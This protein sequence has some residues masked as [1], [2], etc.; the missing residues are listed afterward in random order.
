MT[1]HS[2]DHP[3]F[4]PPRTGENS[5]VDFLGLRQANLDMMAEMIPSTNNVT[6]YVRPFSLVSWVFWKFYNLC[7][8]SGIKEPSREEIDHFREKIEVLFSWGARLH[9]TSGRVPGTG[10]APPKSSTDGHVQL[11][12]KDWKRVQSSTSLIAALWYGPASKIVTGLGFLMPVPG[13]TGFFRTTGVGI[14]LAKAL[15]VQLRQ[16][17]E[18]YDRLL[19]TLKPVMATENDAVAMWKLWSPEEITA[20]EREAFASALYSADEIG[21]FNSLAGKRSTTLALAM[22]Y[23]TQCTSA[24]TIHE[25]R[26]GMA[27]SISQGGKSYGLPEELIVA[28]N[29]WL[30]LQMRQLQRLSMECLLSWCE[31][32]IL[33]DRINETSAMAE[34]FIANWDGDEH[35]FDGEEAL[36]AM[37]AALDDQ[38]SDIDGFISAVLEER[39]ANP[40]DIIADIQRL[41]K[42][43]NLGYAQYA[44]TGI[45]LCVAYAG[46]A[47]DDARLLKLGG[48][49]R[50]SLDNLR[51]R[52]VGLG[53]VSVREAFQF[54]LESMIISQHFATAVN[55]FDGQNQRLRLTIEETGLEALVGKQWEPTVTEDRLATL[56]SLAAQSGLVKRDEDGFSAKT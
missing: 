32:R 40:F 7:E 19:E 35:G 39:L 6:D 47:A 28:R 54:I 4:L 24:V 10:A 43:R 33:K 12:F 31:G 23:L 26:R 30:T 45:L 11:T 55:R 3:F 34:L 15:D 2:P 22:Q 53:E 17:K 18:L 13:Y 9:E 25:V 37:I 38:A 1:I 5:G 49:V 48:P 36:S 16:D 20:G 50:V 8:A 52:L 51:R 21:N 56:L 29:N 14:L 41:F 44:F 46:A 27:F 42:N